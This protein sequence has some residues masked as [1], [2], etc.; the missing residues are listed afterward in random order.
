MP[1]PLVVETQ[2]LPPT[3]FF[4]ELSLSPIVILEKHE[5][6]QKRSFRNRVYIAG[7]NGRQL[8]SVPLVNGKNQQLAI[9]KV[10]I[11]YDED[12]STQ[13]FSHI[14]NAYS[15]APYYLYYIDGVREILTQNY[16]YLWDFNIAFLNWSLSALKMDVIAKETTQYQK[17][18]GNGSIDLR[19]RFNPT[20]LFWQHQ[21]P[22]YCQVFEEKYDF[23]NNLSVLDLIMCTGPEAKNYL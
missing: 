1:K 22:Y 23:L 8:L 11:S 4:R 15:N 6:Y 3:V 17:K 2:C 21:S 5:N 10:I 9:H 19:N 18:I 16:H 12:W 7:P 14:K 13:W 20:S